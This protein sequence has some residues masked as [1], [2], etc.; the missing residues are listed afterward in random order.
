[1]HASESPL[2]FMVKA[3][4]ST[5]NT[6]SFPADVVY[7]SLYAINN[8]REVVLTFSQKEF[9][10]YFTV[11]PIKCDCVGKQ[12]PCMIYVCLCCTYYCEFG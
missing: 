3:I 10:S 11:I 9:A 6:S 8:E 2:D 4:I 5:M 1:M 12:T 7:Q